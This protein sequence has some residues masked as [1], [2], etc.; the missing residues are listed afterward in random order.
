MNHIS[1][2]WTLLTDVPRHRFPDLVVYWRARIA[3]GILTAGITVN[4]I[5]LAFYKPGGK[6]ELSQIIFSAS[7]GLL[8]HWLLG[9]SPRFMFPLGIVLSAL[10]LTGAISAAFIQ[11]NGALGA[12]AGIPLAVVLG[13]ILGGRKGLYIATAAALPLLAVLSW[14]AFTGRIDPWPPN[15]QKEHLGL[16]VTAMGGLT[17]ILAVLLRTLDHVT[18]RLAATAQEAQEAQRLADERA[19]R[20][21]Q[22][23]QLKT[24]F[25]HNVSHEFR[26]PLSLALGLQ[27]EAAAAHPQD[28]TLSQIRRQLQR[29]LKLVNSILDIS[30]I[31]AGA[32]QL[33]FQPLDVSQITADLC[34]EFRSAMEK[35]DLRLTVDCPPLPRPAYVDRAAWEKIVLNLLSN[36]LKYT[37]SGEITVSLRRQGE[38]LALRVRD[39]GAGIPREYQER[40]FERFERVPAAQ[41]RTREGAGIGLSLVRD[42]VHL[43]SGKIQVESEPGQGSTF[44]VTLPLGKDHLPA[45][46]LGEADDRPGPDASLYLAEALHWV[47]R[48]SGEGPA[49][50]Q[51]APEGSPRVLIAED[52]EDMGA[53]LARMLSPRYTVTLAGDGEE[54]LELCRRA[55]PDLVLSDVMM[56]KLDGLGLLRALRADP[57][58]ATLPILLLSARAELDSTVQGLEGLA[59]DYLAKP[60]PAQELQARVHAHL[61]LGQARR[62]AVAAKERFMNLVAHELRGPLAVTKTSAQLLRVKINRGGE[63]DPGLMSRMEHGIQRM[64]LLINDLVDTARIESGKFTLTPRRCDLRDLCLQA[65]DDQQVATERDIELTLPGPS[66]WVMADPARLGQVLANLITNALK[67][68]DEESAVTVTL[69]VDPP[70]PPPA[71]RARAL[72]EVKDEGPGIPE[73]QLDRI[74]QAFYRVPGAKASGLGLGL[75]LSRELIERQGGALEVRSVVGEGSTFTVVLPLEPADLA[76]L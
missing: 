4:L 30:A 19:S 40:I 56:P 53:Y 29:L 10:T 14:A 32:G 55:P 26:T 66:V 62:E 63:P 9:K 39:T 24:E 76:S 70:G 6:T 12:L 50:V 71:G 21:A 52:N 60:T 31:Q 13:G 73:D 37:L 7:F 8:T 16:L 41:A 68:S 67:Y 2:L 33:R 15:Q 49:L 34:S 74:F 27:E 72:V 23:D 59:D 1:R 36:A 28:K 65:V 75:Y 38:Q 48:S 35:A 20:L 51:I 47:G 42:L 64:E 11:K 5:Q 46:R 22:F 43:H 25:F 44:T 58:T 17:V 69:R 54:A 57:R 18:G 61:R 45:S 3:R